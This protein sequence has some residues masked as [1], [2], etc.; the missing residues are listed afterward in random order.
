MNRD[1]L[2][3]QVLFNHA[4]EKFPGDEALKQ[5][6]LSR[7]FSDLYSSVPLVQ[8]ELET[9]Y[10]YLLLVQ[11]KQRG[12]NNEKVVDK[13]EEVAVKEVVVSPSSA[14]VLA[15][16]NGLSYVSE[17][18]YYDPLSKKNSTLEQVVEEYD[19]ICSGIEDLIVNYVEKGKMDSYDAL[20]N[21]KRNKVVD[22]VID[23]TVGGKLD[24]RC[25]LAKI[26]SANLLVQQVKKDEIIMKDVV[27]DMSLDSFDMDNYIN[28][29]F[30]RRR[31]AFPDKY[32]NVWNKDSYGMS[33]DTHVRMVTFDLL[34]R[35]KSQ[36]RSR[37]VIF[38][39]DLVDLHWYLTHKFKIY[40]SD[41][42]RMVEVLDIISKSGEYGEGPFCPDFKSLR[43]YYFF[44]PYITSKKKSLYGVGNEGDVVRK[45]E[46]SHLMNFG[47][48]YTFGTLG[49][50]GVGAS[51]SYEK[52]YFIPI[53]Y[54]KLFGYF[55]ADGV[56]DFFDFGKGEK[57]ILAVD[58]F[59][60]ELCGSVSFSNC[61]L[62]TNVLRDFMILTGIGNLGQCIKVYISV[63]RKYLYNASS[64]NSVAFINVILTGVL[65]YM[66]VKRFDYDVIGDF[67]YKG[68]SVSLRRLYYYLN[69]LYVDRYNRLKSYNASD[70]DKLL[71]G[72]V[73]HDLMIREIFSEV[74]LAT[75]RGVA[76]TNTL[77]SIVFLK[78]L[79]NKNYYVAEGRNYF[80]LRKL[81]K[82]VD[83]DNKGYVRHKTNN[84][85]GKGKL[86]DKTSVSWRVKSDGGSKKQDTDGELSNVYLD[87]DI[88]K[89]SLVNSRSVVVRKS[90]N[91]KPVQIKRGRYFRL[92]DK[93]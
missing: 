84:D 66:S 90:D 3:G 38:D 44:L 47:V 55:I 42:S 63:Y 26:E 89:V 88:S 34:L 75:D 45:N 19:P 57:V 74:D 52:G 11:M 6:N 27:M 86:K 56:M 64:V 54:H 17:N 87:Q 24:H 43:D 85:Y 76:L 40:F 22:K 93:S 51:I 48:A 21:L 79:R 59:K 69:P 5:L 31:R 30:P 62:I 60:L 58:K 20:V 50:K 49:G 1:K 35:I 67:C 7:G 12:Q 28:V 25:D 78:K 65:K 15:D 72:V 68:D 71:K 46:A 41:R 83:N 70:E 10:F 82:L 33:K 9:Y 29:E 77:E 80:F 37:F 13:E 91:D 14:L 73:S 61:V 2:K 4:L 81:P 32:Y 36:Y 16:V 53:N 92:K 8:L 23:V 18:T 39:P